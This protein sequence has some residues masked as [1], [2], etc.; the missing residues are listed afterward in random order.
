MESV[1]CSECGARYDSEEN[2]FCPRCGS[3]AKAAPADAV[4]EVREDRPARRRV[5]AGGV[6]LAIVGTVAL[7]QLLF[8]AIATAEP[9]DATLDLLS[10]VAM[11]QDLPGGELR[12][13]LPDGNHTYV[14][15]AI[16][17]NATQSGSAGN[18]TVLQL[19]NAFSQLNI[20][21]A[22][23]EVGK[24]LYIP[25]GEAGTFDA[26]N[27]DAWVASSAPGAIRGLSAFL[28]F[29]AGLVVLGGVMA[30]RLRFRK[31]IY[32]ACGIA[33]I[34]GL[35]ALILVP[36]AGLF[37]L[38]LPAIATGLIVAGRHQIR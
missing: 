2:P 12:L 15:V 37:L 5:Q 8:A 25:E 35:F 14:L 28:A 13:L 9:D 10:D 27:D 29:F 20:T 16:G 19:D 4:K 6:I 36:A 17:G 31:I 1:D 3:E 11:F 21:I 18:G 30:I 26:A 22:G 38:A 33:L 34:P 32:L 23:N 7:A 24:R